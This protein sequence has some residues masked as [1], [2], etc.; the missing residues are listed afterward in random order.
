MGM[1]MSKLTASN[2]ITRTN[3]CQATY[4][5]GLGLIAIADAIHR[6]ADVIEQQ[7]EKTMKEVITRL[8]KEG[9]LNDT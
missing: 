6:F 8:E 1:V 4:N 5:V 2:L 7:P 3:D 9:L